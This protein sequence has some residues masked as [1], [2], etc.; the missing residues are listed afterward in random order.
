MPLLLMRVDERLLHGQVVV[1][2]GMHLRPDRYIVVDDAL[3]SEEWEQELYRLAVPDRV[4]VLF[5][6]V[7]E[8]IPA[9][10][11]WRAAE[12]KAILLTRDLTSM[13][14]LVTE[15]DRGSEPIHLGGIHHAPGRERLLSFVH[16]GAVER[17]ELELLLER[18]FTVV[19]RELPGTPEIPAETL[20][21]GPKGT[22][23]FHA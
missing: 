18:G 12:E 2:W 7:A 10:P 5:R 21:P 22:P 19:A 1:G 16:L 4:E 17:K 20:S 15:G 23:R 3:A 6:S 13:R 9:L 8:G 11:H 14:R